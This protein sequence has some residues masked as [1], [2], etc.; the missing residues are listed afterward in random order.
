MSATGNPG[1]VAAFAQA[2]FVGEIVLTLW[3][4]IKSANPRAPDDAAMSSAF[5]A[6]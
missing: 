2:A 4:L 6:R 5:T 3:L 1:R